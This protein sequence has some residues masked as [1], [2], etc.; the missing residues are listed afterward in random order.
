MGGLSRGIIK[1]QLVWHG[2]VENKLR[3][4]LGEFY[5]REDNPALARTQTPIDVPP[6]AYPSGPVTRIHTPFKA[7]LPI[8]HHKI[9]EIGEGGFGEVWKG[10]DLD[11]GTLIAV[12]YI[13]GK[14]KIWQNWSGDRKYEPE[15]EWRRRWDQTYKL[16][17][18]EVEN[19]SKLSHVCVMSIQGL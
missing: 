9:C 19:L 6:T 2:E 16:L 5:R 7:T 11:A 4:Q 10:V 3:P 1:F 8:R 12:K 15:R 13:K 14:K 18:R 17:K